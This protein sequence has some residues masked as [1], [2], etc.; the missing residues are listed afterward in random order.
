[1]RI[2]VIAHNL[3]VAGGLS[4]GRNTIASLSRVADQH[5]YL[6]TLPGDVGYESIKLPSRVET[7]Y[8][9][10][11]SGARGALGQLWLDF[12]SLESLVNA[13]RPD[14]IWGLGNFGL[15]RPGCPQAIVCQDSHFVYDPRQQPRPVWRNGPDARIARWRMVRSLPATQL[16]FCQTQTMV[17]RV[18]ET[19]GFKGRMAVMANA[20]SRFGLDAA[21][22]RPAVF[23]RLAG[24]CVLLALTRYYSHKNLEILAE[25][26]AKHAAELGNVVVLLTIDP[27][28]GYGAG[29]FMRMI[30]RPALRAHFTNVGPVAQAELQGYFRHS[31]ALIQPTVLESFSTTY[32]E[33]MQF[34]T[35]ILTS[36]LD[37]AR[38]VCGEAALY[39]DP[40]SADSV[41]EVVRRF[42][43][44]PNLGPELV[45][46]GTE[47]MQT[48]FRSWDEIV[49]EAMTHVERLRAS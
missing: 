28:Q 47:R 19:F 31:A 20:V 32:L 13:W 24:K 15:K 44:S 41:F 5:E 21:P 11:S 22:S 40:W 8:F 3:R 42:Q 10:R 12:V 34:G 4:V 49:G 26:F 48:Y 18:R 27:R 9:R 7:R 39:F 6:L 1:M 17:E 37:F 35:P 43:T 29:S 38:E 30:D 16:V 23:D 36:D 46:R 2:A 33:A 25:M 14:V 45:R